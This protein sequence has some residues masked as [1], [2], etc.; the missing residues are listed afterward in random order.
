MNKFTKF[1]GSNHIKKNTNLK[2]SSV[3]FA[4]YIGKNC[5]LYRAKIGRFCSIANDVSII[6]S[7]HPT[8]IVST[9]P[10]F[11]KG[12]HPVMRQIGLSMNLNYSH[13]DSGRVDG[14]NIKIGSDV[15]IGESV[16]IMKNIVIGDG[17]IIGTG[18]II[19]KDVPPYSICVGVPAKVIKYRF[20]A[21]VINFLI[22]NQWWNKSKKE[23][24][25]VQSLFLDVDKYIEHE[26]KV[27]E[28]HIHEKY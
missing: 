10:C 21:E 20:N 14:Y 16:K 3:G 26:Q 7:D 8:N 4:T 15:W 11:H 6:I 25:D 13:S 23:I 24:M 1:E 12:N 22:S 9:H 18:A 19:T 5:N 17:A 28:K 27:I 2:D